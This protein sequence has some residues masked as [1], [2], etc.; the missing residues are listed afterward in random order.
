MPRDDSAFTF[1]DGYLELV[2]NV[3]RRAAGHAQCAN[4][5]HMRLVNL[6]I[7]AV[8]RKY[9]ITSSSGKEKN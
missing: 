4:G 6:G 5:D 1:K 3:T 2:V 9:S 7:I 8:F